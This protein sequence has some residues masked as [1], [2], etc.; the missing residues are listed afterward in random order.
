MKNRGF[1]I[2]NMFF[3]MGIFIILLI[4]VS[5]IVHNM[6]LD[7]RDNPLL[8]P[9]DKT[10]YKDNDR[11]NFDYSS[12]EKNLKTAAALYQKEY[13]PDF[14]D[15]DPMYV[16]AKKLIALDYLN[17]L[18]DGQVSCDGYAKI[19]YDNVVNVTPY[20]KC[21]NYYISEGYSSSLAE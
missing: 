4:V 20:I 3:F 2:S 12:I 10:E 7:D 5:L 21:G 13:Y 18:T 9:N 1:G 11:S 14:N 8:N 15:K 6:H 16:T 19:T 17:V